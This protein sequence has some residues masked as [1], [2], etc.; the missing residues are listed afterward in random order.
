MTLAEIKQVDVGSWKDPK[1]KGEPV[2]TLAEI[3]PLVSE[4]K[5]F[6]IEI[7]CGPEIVPA[8]LKT[9]DDSKI[10]QDRL[11]IIGFDAEV[12][13]AVKTARPELKAY[14]LTSF[15]AKEGETTKHPTLDE[16]LATL[17]R[18][19]ADGLDANANL[20]VLTPDFVKALREAGQELHVWTV[21]DITVA[22]K[23]TDLGVDSITTNRVAAL[24]VA[25]LR[26]WQD[27]Q[28]K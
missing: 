28:P 3:L 22:K 18:I 23:A 19:H 10:P 21:D 15:K 4:G 5:Q 24:R 13:L 12:V 26:A 20:E 6:F 9:I 27:G 2:P 17:K 8:L 14:W 16:T 25:M 1:F 11:R 7:K